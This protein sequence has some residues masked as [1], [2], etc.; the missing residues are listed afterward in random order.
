MSFG[1]VVVR[2]D[3]RGRD[4]GRYMVTMAIARLDTVRGNVPIRIS[5][6]LYLQDFYASF[7][8]RIVS[9]PYI[10]DHLW[11]VAMVKD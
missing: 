5:S 1:R 2:K 10:E 4:L 7:G 11:H 8:F 6:Q 9:E 3:M